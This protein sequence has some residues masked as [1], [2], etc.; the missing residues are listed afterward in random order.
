MPVQWTVSHP[1]R[2]VIAV[3]RGN[4]R[5]LDIEHYLDG[6]VTANAL[7]YRKI[8]DMTQATPNLSDDDLMALGARIRAYIALGKIGPLASSPRQ[9]EPQ[10]ARLFA[11][12]AEPIGDQIFRELT[13]RGK[14]WT[15]AGSSRRRSA[16]AARC[17]IGGDEPIKATPEDV[18]TA[19]GTPC[20]APGCTRRQHAYRK[21][22]A[23]AT[24]RVANSAA[25]SATTAARGAEV[26]KWAAEE[27][28]PKFVALHS[29]P[30]IASDRAGRVEGFD[31]GRDPLVAG[32][33]QALTKRYARRLRDDPQRIV[34]GCISSAP[35]TRV[36]PPFHQEK[37]ARVAERVG[38]SAAA[39]AQC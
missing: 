29:T 4:L 25:N 21:G 30:G 38:E 18:C 34:R 2:L 8:F 24:M 28:E 6:V 39:E 19:A 37:K 12:L 14:G 11:A 32:S 26:G 20:A 16:R 13:W 15:P 33:A 7:A 9:S 35:L 36:P 23:D 27:H 1:T 3:A 5:L 17:R 10:Q 31:D 22:R